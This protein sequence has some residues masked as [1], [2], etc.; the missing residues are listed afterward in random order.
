M[1]DFVILLIELFRNYNVL[2]LG[3]L[4]VLQN[5]GI[6]VGANFLVIVSG[7]FAYAGE[8]NLLALW[9]EVWFFT[10]LGDSLSYWLWR[11]GGRNLIAKYPR[12]HARIE[13]GIERANNFFDKHGKITVFFTRFP[14]SAMG[15]LVNISAG[16]SRYNYKVFV[17]YALLGEF[18]WVSFNLG[19]G[20]W[21]GD[22]VEQ[23]AFII[24]QF[25]ELTVLL[26]IL[27]VIVYLTRVYLRSKKKT[28]S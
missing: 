3:A 18:L 24:S 23:I 7:A 16:T 21:F 20:Y 8:F 27:F 12:I 6:P 14:L 25:G 13:P 4:I 1:S 17:A 11:K 9:G 19:V 10:L 2:F 5:N 22:S 28:I 15:P 26:L